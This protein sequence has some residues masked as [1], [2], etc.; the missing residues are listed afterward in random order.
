MQIWGGVVGQV[1]APCKV[2]RAQRAGWAGRSVSD[3]SRAYQVAYDRFQC[4][5]KKFTQNLE[6]YGEFVAMPERCTLGCIPIRHW[7]GLQR[8]DRKFSYSCAAA[9]NV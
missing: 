5:K 3:V 6:D 1:L 9:K 2:R 7:Q 8:L 4:L